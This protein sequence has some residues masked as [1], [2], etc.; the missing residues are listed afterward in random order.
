M[1]GRENIKAFK[2]LKKTGTRH[3]SKVPDLGANGGL[4]M[5]FYDD[6]NLRL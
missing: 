6:K 4:K 3:L 2:E 5:S 1:S